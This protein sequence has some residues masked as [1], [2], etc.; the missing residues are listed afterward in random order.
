MNF[1]CVLHFSH[2]PPASCALCMWSHQKGSRAPRWCPDLR[3]TRTLKAPSGTV[4]AAP[5]STTLHSTAVN[6]ARCR[7]T[8]ELKTAARRPLTVLKDYNPHPSGICWV[9][10]QV[11]PCQ[12]VYTQSY[13]LKKSH[14]LWLSTRPA[15]IHYSR[16]LWPLI[17]VGGCWILYWTAGNF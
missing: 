10:L 2:K 15:H 1:C 14:C 11:F 9:C 5:S 8:P 16:A 7:V 3:G 17:F 13:L 6:S 4:I 12:S